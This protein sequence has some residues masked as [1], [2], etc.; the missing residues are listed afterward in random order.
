MRLNRTILILLLDF[1]S[2]HWDLTTNRILI[3]DIKLLGWSCDLMQVRLL[4]FK[5][6]VMIFLKLFHRLKLY[7][8]HSFKM[9]KMSKN[10]FIRSLRF[11]CTLYSIIYQAQFPDKETSYYWK[12]FLILVV[13]KFNSRIT[14]FGQRRAKF[15]I[16]EI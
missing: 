12:L 5:S 15:S 11:V 4:F 8:L 13:A 7:H 9:K 1:Q 10:I 6:K 3:R 16:R 2:S 14:T